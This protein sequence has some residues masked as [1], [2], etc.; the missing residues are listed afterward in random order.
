IPEFIV[1]FSAMQ[2]LHLKNCKE[3]LHINGLPPYIKY[4]HA[5]GCESLEHCV[6][7]SSFLKS[8][9][10][11][12]LLLFS[13]CYKLR[14]NDSSVAILPSIEIYVSLSAYI[15]VYIVNKIGIKKKW[16]KAVSWR[17]LP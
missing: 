5:E 10:V 3:L 8:D 9:S 6:P 14:Q 16:M 13:G 12:S 7:L 17:P 1:K 15:Y 2:V 11:S 4:L